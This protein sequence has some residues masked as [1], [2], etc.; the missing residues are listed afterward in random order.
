MRDEDTCI[1]IDARKIGELDLFRWKRGL[2]QKGWLLIHSQ[3]FHPVRLFFGVYNQNKTQHD[4]TKMTEWLV[5]F[6]TEPRKIW[7]KGRKLEVEFGVFGREGAVD[8]EVCVG[9]GLGE[10]AGGGYR[11]FLDCACPVQTGG[12]WSW[13]WIKA[14]NTT[15]RLGPDLFIFFLFSLLESVR[16][17]SRCRSGLYQGKG[18]W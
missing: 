10:G 7:R 17:V 4:W 3:N 13:E 5:L 2:I 18:V 9:E 14:K 12:L 6:P 16:G 15:R 11:M 8:L 1:L